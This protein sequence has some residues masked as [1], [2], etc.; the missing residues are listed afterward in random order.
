MKNNKYV[1]L[2]LG[3][4]MTDDSFTLTIADTSFV[5]LSTVLKT[6][7][8]G[9]LSSQL[10]KDS[11]ESKDSRVKSKEDIKWRVKVLMELFGKIGGDQE[12]A[13]VVLTRILNESKDLEDI[14]DQMKEFLL[15]TKCLAIIGEELDLFEY[16][17]EEH[18]DKVI[19]NTLFTFLIPLYKFLKNENC[20]SKRL[21][22]F[23]WRYTLFIV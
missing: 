18:N 21:A 14:N 9:P 16:L 1:G 15:S 17:C 2:V 5:V 19:I 10:R 20:T 12:L 23:I 6:T 7:L 3:T 11:G 22:S 8:G 4:T 13:G